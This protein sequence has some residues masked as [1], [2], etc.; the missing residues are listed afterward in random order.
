MIVMEL[1]NIYT[2]ESDYRSVG[3]RPPV[4]EMQAGFVGIGIRKN[5]QKGKF[6]AMAIL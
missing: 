4:S 1:K 2:I 3:H 5:I 6:G